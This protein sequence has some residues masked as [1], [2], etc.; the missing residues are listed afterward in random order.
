MRVPSFL[1]PLLSVS[2]LI[3][4]QGTVRSDDVLY[5]FDQGSEPTSII[6]E[7]AE[8]E[9][10]QGETG[11]ALQVTLHG[12]G[13]P[14]RIR[15]TSPGW[16]LSSYR[17]VA[18]DVTNRDSQPIAVLAQITVGQE[19]TASRSVVCLEPGET[20]TMLLTFFRSEPP[21]YMQKFFRDMR[22]LPGGVLA[23]WL[24]PDLTRLDTIEIS[25]S[26]PNQSMRFSIDNIRA[27]GRFAPPSE[28]ELQSDF[29]PFVDRYG[30]YMHGTWPG[31]TLS[32]E[33]ITDQHQAELL[34]LDAHPGPVD[35]D[36]YGG[37]AAGPQLEATGHFRTEKYRGK[38]WLVDP[39]GRL[40]WS[41]GITGVQLSQRTKIWQRENYFSERAPDG[42]F[43]AANLKRKFG[44]GWQEGAGEL[45][46]RRLRSWGMNTF[47]NWSDPDLYQMRRT[48]YVV[49]VGTGI[50]KM[51]P[52]SI[53]E[54]AFRVKVRKRLNAKWA[55]EF[56]DDPWCLGVFVD[57]ELRWPKKNTAQVAE[58]YYKVVSEQL[59]AVAPNVL[60][61]G[62]RIHGDGEP[63]AAYRAAA[64]Y[65]DVV[66]MNRYQLAV[67]HED[68][69]ADS[70]DKPMIIGEFHFGALDRG[71]PHTGLLAVANQRQRA[72][73]YAD[74]VHQ[75]LENDRIVGA[76][77]FQ[78]SDQ[79]FTGR[80]DGENY[81]IGFV[82]IVDRPYP[83]MIE[84]SREM[85]DTLYRYRL[86]H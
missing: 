85:G 19:K 13:E 10:V 34:D 44:Q 4:S 23:H 84:A 6:H 49:A 75:A 77:W 32:A 39:D 27:T 46:H 8:T 30:Q 38:W 1:L 31:K 74:Y 53:D 52:P 79:L 18:I 28:Q 73:A 55:A 54:A 64:A 14:S 12:K 63:R 69:P 5:D 2:V 25:K 59:K 62:S 21:E 86:E 42:D 26:R 45:A 72:R 71:L 83:D 16:D 9:L 80:G 47:A 57:N 7:R 40:F 60:Y 82:D 48:P 70:L 3:V 22:G 24:T 78:Y 68:L 81:Q 15:L 50:S 56:K 33:G 11:R 43:R 61:L 67:V 51:V 36:R 29:F 35:W 41:H 20:D 17:G 37:W 76:H 66:S 65:C 58:T